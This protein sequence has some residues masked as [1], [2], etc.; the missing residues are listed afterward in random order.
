VWRHIATYF[1]LGTI[2]GRVISFT[3][4]Q[5]YHEKEFCYPLKM[6]LYT[7]FGIL[8]KN[9]EKHNYLASAFK[10]CYA[11][12]KNCTTFC[13]YWRKKF[14]KLT[15]PHSYSNSKQ[16]MGVSWT[17]LTISRTQFALWP[18]QYCNEKLK[19][20]FNIKE[21]LHINVELYSLRI[22]NA[23]TKMAY[24]L[25]CIYIENTFMSFCKNR[26]F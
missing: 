5:L 19:F 15:L 8:Y 17:R 21:M 16:K 18:S 12:W 22:T 25:F 2:W 1:N 9:S 13:Q 14:Q 11:C 26:I 4:R 3:P 20:E 23:M 6:W 24:L 7:L 10:S